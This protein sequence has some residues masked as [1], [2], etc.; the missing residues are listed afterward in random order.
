MNLLAL[1]GSLRKQSY[2][3]AA[4]DALTRLA[5]T[6]VAVKVHKIDTLPLFNPDRE[7]EDIQS[8]RQL[9]AALGQAESGVVADLRAGQRS[10]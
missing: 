2:N 6:Q 7:H 5:P 9:K 1:S 8:V 4:L 10:R 3:S